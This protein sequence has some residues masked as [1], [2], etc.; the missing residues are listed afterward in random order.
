MSLRAR[1]LLTDYTPP[2]G[3]LPPPE[4]VD[5]LREVDPTAELIY[6]GK[7]RW[8]LGSVQPDRE[9]RKLAVRAMA[10]YRTVLDHTAPAA[11]SHV[12]GAGTPLQLDAK[13]RAELRYRLW[14]KKLQ[15]QGFRDITL[16]RQEPDSAVV[17]AFRMM[18]WFHRH[19]QAEAER[20]ALA[21]AEKPSKEERERLERVRDY[22][23][24]EGPDVYRK[25]ILKKINVMTDVEG[26]D[27]K[28]RAEPEPAAVGSAVADVPT[29][30]S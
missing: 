6:V 5:G 28:T 27:R 2:G 15:L 17:D 23:S 30:G 26:F 16:F 20:R 12:E 14:R 1:S 21:D 29:N 18:D 8:L 19:M 7:G 10:A 4:V 3:R 25:A 24:A 11:G 13:T 9:R 22:W